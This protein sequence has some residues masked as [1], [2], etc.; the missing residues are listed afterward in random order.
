M[1]CKNKKNEIKTFLLTPTLVNFTGTVIRK[2][3]SLPLQVKDKH[4]IG[5]IYID[6][7]KTNL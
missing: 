2:L 5:K 6:V 4:Y 1:N 3:Q 7:E